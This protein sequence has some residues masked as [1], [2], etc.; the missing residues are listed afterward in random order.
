M[1]TEKEFLR[2]TGH[3]ATCDCG[4]EVELVTIISHPMRVVRNCS[5]GITSICYP[6]D[7]DGD[8]ERLL[9]WTQKSRDEARRENAEAKRL[10]RAE[11]GHPDA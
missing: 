1:I 3:T 6:F 11:N 5:C 8:H 10:C 4:R 2:L 7:Q 9:E